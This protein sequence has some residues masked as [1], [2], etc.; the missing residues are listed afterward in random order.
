MASRAREYQKKAVVTA[1]GAACLGMAPM[2]AMTHGHR[3]LGFVFIAVQVVLLVA[4]MRFF[5][6]MKKARQGRS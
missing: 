3:W 2:L 6:E 4:A 5:V 1:A